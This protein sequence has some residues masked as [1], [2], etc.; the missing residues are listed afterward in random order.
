MSK[1]ER[2]P[3]QVDVSRVIE[4]LAAEIYQSPLALLRENTQNA[5]DAV[6][7]RRYLGQEFDPSIEVEVSGDAITI[8]DNGIGM[9]QE[10]LRSHYWRAGSSSKNND[11]AR[12]AGVV[13]TFGIG[14]M[15]NFGIADVLSLETESA[16]TGERTESSAHKASLSTTEECIELRAIQPTGRPGTRVVAHIEPGRSLDVAQAVAYISDFVAYVAIPVRVNGELASHRD[17]EEA[18]PAPPGEEL[19]LGRQDL[20]VSVTAEVALRLAAGTGEV[21]A[22]VENVAYQG[23]TLPGKLI[24]RQGS[25]SLRTFRNGFGLATV[26]VASLYHFGGVADFAALVPTAGR[27]ALTTSS[28]QL[29][30]SV[31]SA[32]EQ[33]VSVAI[34]SRPE[35]DLNSRFMEWARRNGRIDLCGNLQ[36]RVEPAR[37]TPLAVLREQSRDRPLL[38]YAGNDR[39]MIESVGSDDSPLVVLAN[40]QPRRFC[41]EQF[42][43]RYC[44]VNLVDDAPKV[45][46]SKPEGTWS[47]AEQALVFRIAATLASDYFYPASVSLG[48][49]S[50]GLPIVVEASG[51]PPAIVL[52]PAAP[53]FSVIAGLY[54]TNIQAFASMVKDFVRNLVFPRIADRVP[55]STRQGAEAFLRT[56]QRTRDVF[57]YELDDLSSL[58]GIWTEYVEGHLTMTEAAERSARIVRQSVQIVDSTAAVAV[59]DVVPDVVDNES[60]VGSSH[61]ELGP[62]PPILRAELS[63]DAKLLTIAPAEAPLRGYRCFISLSERSRDEQGAFFLQPH[64]TSIVWGGQKV[65]F[66]FEH[67]SGQFGLY[68]DLQ[69]SRVVAESGGGPFPTAT[70]VLADRIYIPIPDA[71]AAAF[72]PAQGER[73]RFEVHCDLLYTDLR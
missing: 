30:Q 19:K 58:S 13:G 8:D 33:A 15:A 55:S 7:L 9:T 24:L 44:K 71:V 14:A 39:S 59:R 43:K 73:K 17:I 18:I 47:T 41:E 45:L 56:I 53:T 27:E 46:L 51:D 62:A 3:F 4:V 25:P 26:G 12:A 36:A 40:E 54:T 35:A 42:L 37:R 50:H 70:I 22:R 66:V 2:I 1:V 5:F 63:A 21:W 64:S 6:L 11:E 28:M 60:V 65:L 31:V 34:A 67:H 16:L 29:L 32:V 61:P 10:D 72:I 20:S 68:Y 49:L 52:D 57:E 23:G 48:E 69:T 38:V